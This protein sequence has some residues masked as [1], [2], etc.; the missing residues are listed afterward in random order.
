MIEPYPQ[1][2]QTS[3]Q[4]AK[5]MAESLKYASTI[6][7]ALFPSGADI[8]RWFPENFLLFLPCQVVSGDFYHISGREDCAWVAVGDCTG[9]GVPGA[10]MSILGLTLLN[11]VISQN[12]LIRTAQAMNR[13]REHVMRAMGQTG[14]QKDQRDGIDLALCRIDFR[15]HML[16]F[17]GAFNP[18]YLVRNGSLREIPGDTM[19]VGIGSEQE[20]S[21][22]GTHIQLSEGDMVYLFSDGFAD[23]FGGPHGKKYKYKPFRKLITSLAE[24]PVLEQRKQAET[25]FLS[26]KGNHRQID[27]VTLFG[28]RYRTRKYK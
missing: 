27:D 1:S 20:R 4:H 19:P 18:V 22:S 15:A 25:E 13:I 7:K 11:S 5:D 10:L 24:L 23:Q 16:E 14:S 21:F 12:P 6:Q 26:W 3:S 9:H 17:T 8:H 28:F 2:S